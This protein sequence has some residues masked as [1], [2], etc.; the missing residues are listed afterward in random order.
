MS[1]VS[2]TG[3]HW[4]VETKM[5]WVERGWETF[6]QRTTCYTRAVSERFAC[7]KKKKEHS[8]QSVQL[9]GGLHPLFFI[10]F[11]FVFRLVISYQTQLVYR[12]DGKIKAASS[13]Y[14]WIPSGHPKKD[15]FDS[16]SFDIFFTH[17]TNKKK[18]GKKFKY[19]IYFDCN[20]RPVCV[21]C[22]VWLCRVKVFVVPFG[23][24]ACGQLVF[25]A[26]NYLSKRIRVGT[27]AG[28][29]QMDDPGRWLVAKWATGFCRPTCL[30]M[31]DILKEKL[32]TC[33]TKKNRYQSSEIATGGEKWR[34]QKV[35]G[36]KWR[37][38]DVWDWL[39]LLTSWNAAKTLGQRVAWWRRNAGWHAAV[40][41][42]QK[43]KRLFSLSFF[44]LSG[45]IGFFHFS[46]S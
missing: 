7:G 3:S 19:P 24:V 28:R 22:V 1:N 30:K 10:C 46:R 33:L 2:A 9:V 35:Q 31:A 20:A 25:P 4:K 32:S 37:K 21:V 39:L 16:F 17:K 12:I 45:A 26:E 14:L 42:G 13:T 44:I 34:G 27:M 29:Y 15:L 38:D 23:Q 11:V 36:S 40:R 18:K 8:F 5:A 43:A 41:N 6:F